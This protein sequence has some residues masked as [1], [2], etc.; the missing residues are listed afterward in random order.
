VKIFAAGAAYFFLVFGAG[1]ILGPIRITLLVPRIGARWAELLEM[2]V[3]LAV[4]IMASRW[5]VEHFSLPADVSFRLGTGCLALALLLA[6]EF[7]LV[8][9]LRRMTIRDYLATRD[10]VSGTAYYLMLG[11][12]ALMPLFVGRD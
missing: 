6:A 8:L 2:P 3:M 1:F 9:R 4:I 10:P 11:V 12:F 7:S 5:V